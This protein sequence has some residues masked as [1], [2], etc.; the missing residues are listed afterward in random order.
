MIR[1]LRISG[2]PIMKY[3]NWGSHHCPPTFPD[4]IVGKLLQ[5][6]FIHANSSFY[7]CGVMVSSLSAFGQYA[8]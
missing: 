5:F 7:I 2:L 8:K 4:S 1:C 3:G 6:V